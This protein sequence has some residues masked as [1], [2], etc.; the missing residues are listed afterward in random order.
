MQ[1]VTD[2][3]RLRDANLADVY[4]DF[5]E[6]R[7]RAHLKHGARGNSREDAPANDREWL[8]ILGEEFGEVCR[9][10]TYD[11]EKDHLREELVQLGAMTAAW[12]AAIDSQK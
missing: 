10:L 4:I 9:A 11:Q 12:I 5:H 7:V 8:P 3:P 1:R 2:H 6:E